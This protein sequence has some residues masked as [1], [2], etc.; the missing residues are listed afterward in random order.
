MTCPSAQHR[1]R[2]VIPLR[3]VLYT[4]L[5]GSTV[6]NCMMR[7]DSYLSLLA[8]LLL[9]GRI[10]SEVPCQLWL[11]SGCS[12]GPS[13]KVSLWP[14]A[15]KVA[16][17][18]LLPKLVEVDLKRLAKTLRSEG[19]CDRALRIFPSLDTGGH[20]K[21][22][23][24]AGRRRG[25]LRKE[26]CDLAKFREKCFG[27]QMRPKDF[28]PLIAAFVLSIAACHLSSRR[29]RLRLPRSAR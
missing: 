21:E 8:L 7:F 6:A 1:T 3:W 11:T 15:A 2:V 14:V 17:R 10:R 18:P 25:S 20:R 13:E 9:P 23:F 19:H 22:D 29:M 27:R 16:V 4:D 12:P 24:Q 26:Q 28:P 5:V